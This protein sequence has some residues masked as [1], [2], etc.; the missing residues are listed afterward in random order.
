M[1]GHIPQASLPPAGESGRGAASDSVFRWGRGL[2]NP[3]SL[4]CGDL[5]ALAGGNTAGFVTLIC[6]P[7]SGPH[8]ASRTWFPL[9]ATLPASVPLAL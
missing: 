6:P 7:F 2:P 5:P 8:N 9:L 3:G 1:A 4:A